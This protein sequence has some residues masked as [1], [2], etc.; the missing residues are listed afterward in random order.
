[1][2]RQTAAKGVTVRATAIAAV[3]PVT[4]GST[5]GGYVVGTAKSVGW[6]QPASSSL[7]SGLIGA[8]PIAIDAS[9]WQA[10]AAAQTAV[11]LTVAADGTLSQ[12]SGQAVGY[13]AD[14]SSLGQSVVMG[15]SGP[16][17]RGAV[18]S[19]IGLRALGNRGQVIG[20]GAID[21]LTISGSTISFQPVQQRVASSNASAVLVAPLPA[22]TD[23]AALWTLHNA[24][25]YPLY[26]PTL[27]NRLSAP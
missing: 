20:F 9:Q 5:T 4:S 17:Q 12:S 2:D 24:V 19:A 13:L 14:Q 7:P 6:A 23:A 18:Q 27:V 21:A 16:F 11:A 22:G 1:M 15:A 10:L 8:V 3:G 25:S 26:A